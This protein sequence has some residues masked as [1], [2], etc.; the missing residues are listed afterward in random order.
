M[1]TTFDLLVACVRAL[2]ARGEAPADLGTAPLE[3]STTIDAL[4]LDS[5]GKL[6]LLGELEDRSGVLLSEGLVA[7]VRTL[8]ELAGAVWSLRRAA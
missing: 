6:S 2:A 4:A 8:G 3:W 5:L 7:G 1:D